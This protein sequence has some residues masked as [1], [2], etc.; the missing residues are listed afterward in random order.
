MR[1]SN[2]ALLLLPGTLTLLLL[3][4]RLQLLPLGRLLLLPLLTATVLTPAL[5]LGNREMVKPQ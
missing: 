1:S 4:L 2:G 3:Q 5:L